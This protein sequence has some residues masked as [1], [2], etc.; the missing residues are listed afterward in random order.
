MVAADFIFTQ[1]MSVK[2]PAPLLP[3]SLYP[4]FAEVILGSIPNGADPIVEW[5]SFLLPHARE[6]II[7]SKT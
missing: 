4:L 6:K 3:E 5:F 7:T 2:W 1:I